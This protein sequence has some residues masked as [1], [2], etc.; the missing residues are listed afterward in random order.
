MLEL[1]LL[2]MTKAQI[3]AL[4]LD[5]FRKIVR[6]HEGFELKAYL[7]SQ[8][9]LTVGI[10][11]KVVPSDKIKLNDTIT[12]ARALSF[13]EKDVAVAFNAAKSQAQD[14]GKYTSDFI[15]ALS[16]V[17]YQ[18]GSGWKDKFYN[19][20]ALLK[21]G[22]YKTAVSN[23][24]NSLWHSQTPDRVNNFIASIKSAYQ[25]SQIG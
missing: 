11:H 10:G 12:I 6:Q 22:D 24:K 25:G 9:I 20:Y 16:E 15:V 2:V 18:L 3:E 23:L 8:G 19:T 5:S 13:F 1:L 17:N 4:A 21:K 14:I 7:D